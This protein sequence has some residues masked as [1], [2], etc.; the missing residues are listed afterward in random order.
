MRNRS[1][2]PECP[3][4]RQRLTGFITNGKTVVCT[5]RPLPGEESW[6]GEWC[7]GIHWAVGNLTEFEK[8]WTELDAASISL[9]SNESLLAEA[10]RVYKEKRQEL[11]TRGLSLAEWEV[12]RAKHSDRDIVKKALPLANWLGE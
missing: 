1:Y 10:E 12:F 2:N 8:I 4:E 3:I 7:G 5:S 11:A 6:K 9:V